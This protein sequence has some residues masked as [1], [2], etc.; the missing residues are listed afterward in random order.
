MTLLRLYRHLLDYCARLFLNASSVCTGIFFKLEAKKNVFLP[1]P[2]HVC[3]ALLYIISCLFTFTQWN[4]KFYKVKVNPLCIFNYKY[5]KA[6]HTVLVYFLDIFGSSI[7][8]GKV[9]LRNL[10]ALTFARLIIPVYT[11]LHKVSFHFCPIMALLHMFTEEKGG[12]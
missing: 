2:I 10:Q 3:K 8:L 12:L 7:A 6:G 1:I 11:G 5:N 9:L 4:T